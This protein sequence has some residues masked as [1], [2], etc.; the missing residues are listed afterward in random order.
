MQNKSTSTDDDSDE[1]AHVV[2]NFVGSS[3]QQDM[4]MITAQPLSLAR[5]V[6][7]VEA[8]ECGVRV[9]FVCVRL[10]QGA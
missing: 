4:V 6:E 1:D 7:F 3:G 8:D 5:L 10:R 9:C 2:V